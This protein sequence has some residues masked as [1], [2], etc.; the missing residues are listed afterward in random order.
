MARRER[1]TGEREDVARETGGGDIEMVPAHWIQ[2]PA[3]QIRAPT[4]AA[5]PEMRGGRRR[6]LGGRGGRRRQL[7]GEGKE[8]AAAAGTA[9]GTPCARRDHNRLLRHGRRQREERA[10]VMRWRDERAEKEEDWGG[11]GRERRG[12]VDGGVSMVFLLWGYHGP[13]HPLC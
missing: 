5:S 4:R 9:G 12:W 3:C 10:E 2:L 13:G 1:G 6:W 7:L 8:G 11:A